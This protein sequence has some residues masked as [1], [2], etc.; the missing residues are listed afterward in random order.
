MTPSSVAC[1][2]PCFRY[3]TAR[4]RA[5]CG[6]AVVVIVPLESIWTDAYCEATFSH[7]EM[8]RQ[9][10]RFQVGQPTAKFT[11]SR[12]YKPVTCM[13]F[14]Y[15]T[16]QE[17][18]LTRSTDFGAL[19]AQRDFPAHAQK[20]YD[21]IGFSQ[22]RFSEPHFEIHLAKFIYFPLLVY[23]RRLCCVRHQPWSFPSLG[24]STRKIWPRL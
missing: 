13:R 3:Q 17:A 23:T 14:C 19:D 4:K 8:Q 15:R 10:L 6:P 2:Y 12:G 20:W 18:S 9:H 1:S 11:Y 24:L 7:A 5:I 22:P 16:R 21:T